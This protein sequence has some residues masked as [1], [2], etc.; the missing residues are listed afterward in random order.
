VKSR[1][2]GVEKRQLAIRGEPMSIGD[3]RKHRGQ[4]RREEQRAALGP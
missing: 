4:R 2:N 1:K 3:D